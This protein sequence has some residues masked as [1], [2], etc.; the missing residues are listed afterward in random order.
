MPSTTDDA[1]EV[2]NNILDC[3]SKAYP[4]F[5]HR[6]TKASKKE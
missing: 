5:K 3:L 4:E 6:L 1:R 2:M